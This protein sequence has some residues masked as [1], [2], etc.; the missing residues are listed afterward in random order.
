MNL[1]INSPTYK[2]KEQSQTIVPLIRVAFNR[3]YI[4]SCCLSL[5]MEIPHPQPKGTQSLQSWRNSPVALILNNCGAKSFKDSCFCLFWIWEYKMD[6][7]SSSFLLALA[8]GK[9]CCGLERRL[10]GW[11]H[12]L[13][14]QKTVSNTRLQRRSDTSDLCEH[15]HSCALTHT[16]THTPT[17]N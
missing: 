2:T 10:G 15:L 16:W 1:G 5:E 3:A 12:L 6:K 7:F 9:K 13:L 11:E 8:T 4:T 17:Q 14:I